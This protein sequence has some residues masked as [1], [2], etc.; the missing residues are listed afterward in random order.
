MSQNL[1][2]GLM[3]CPQPLHRGEVGDEGKPATAGAGPAPELG[4]MTGMSAGNYTH[5]HMKH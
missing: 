2:P 3:P 5:M 1:S 4:G